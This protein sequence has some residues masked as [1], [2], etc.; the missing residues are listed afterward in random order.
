MRLCPWVEEVVFALKGQGN[1]QDAAQMAA[2]MKNH[3]PFL[4][5]RKPRLKEL[6]RPLFERQNL[7]DGSDIPTCIQQLWELGPREFQMVAL[8]LFRKMEKVLCPADLPWITGLIT[9]KSWW[10]T[11]DFLATHGVGVLR[12][13]YPDQTT[14]IIENWIQHDNLW[15][16]RSAVICQVL[17]RKKTDILF[18]EQAII[19]NM[20]RKEFFLKKAIGWALRAY[21]QENPTWV[22]GFV[23]A[24]SEALSGLSI[25]EALKHF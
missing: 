17:Y 2:Y 5:I 13:K 4:G 14:P 12:H 22:L 20:E 21:A 11:V 10:D 24:H 16:T 7:P 23:E 8:E 25:R 1:D 6:T 3:F 18:L 9:Q 15:L 19:H